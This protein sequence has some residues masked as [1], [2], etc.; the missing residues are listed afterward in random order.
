MQNP[1][2]YSMAPG[3]PSLASPGQQQAA[4][5][6]S[7]LNQYTPYGGIAMPSP[8]FSSP[9]QYQSP[10]ASAPRSRRSSGRQS[11][12]KYPG[13][14]CKKEHIVVIRGSRYDGVIKE[15][16]SSAKAIK[17]FFREARRKPNP[18]TKRPVRDLS[19]AKA[20]IEQTAGTGGALDV[21]VMTPQ[22][23]SNSY[24][25]YLEQQTKPGPFQ[26]KW[27]VTAK[28]MNM[29]DNAAAVRA[30]PTNPNFKR[31]RDA[32]GNLVPSTPGGSKSR[33]RK[34][35]GIQYQQQQQQQPSPFNFNSQASPG[36]GFT[37]AEIAQ[38]NRN[39]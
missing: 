16:S 32:A 6:L 39:A 1:V 13:R 15:A 36:G 14:E 25:V 10:G 37:Q 35:Q 31:H 28:P 12:G 7:S 30:T 17:A 22:R 21:M 2:Q 34:S 20:L 9:T 29:G 27:T 33:S 24:S 8:V 11:Q 19:W 3:S 23:K 26:G 4:S 5:A 38:F 18:R